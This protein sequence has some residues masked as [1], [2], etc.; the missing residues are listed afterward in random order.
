MVKCTMVARRDLA[1]GLAAAAE[2]NAAAIATLG[3]Q[4]QAELDE[5]DL[6]QRG[7]VEGLQIQILELTEQSQAER[8]RMNQ[9]LQETEENA[10][11]QIAQLT[12]RFGGFVALYGIEATIALIEAALARSAEN[13]ASRDAQPA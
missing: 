10:R 9:A 2:S 4:H 6:D 12:Q 8:E 13:Q 1:D 7:V 5:R 3:E 11:Q